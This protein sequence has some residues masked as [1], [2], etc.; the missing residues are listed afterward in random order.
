MTKAWLVYFILRI[1]IFVVALVIFVALGIDPLLSALFAAVL[2][3]AISL[4]FLGKQRDAVSSAIY[5]RTQQKP[6]AEV[7]DEV[8]DEHAKK[9]K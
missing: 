3:L 8:L 9:S 5:A 6:K 2:G 7:E 1:A 4:L